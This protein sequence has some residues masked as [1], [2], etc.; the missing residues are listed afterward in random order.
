LFRLSAAWAFSYLSQFSLAI[1]DLA[2][3]KRQLDK[4]KAG[5]KPPF[6]MAEPNDDLHAFGW[7]MDRMRYPS[8]DSKPKDVWPGASVFGVPE[9]DEYRD[10][11][12]FNVAFLN[13]PYLQFMLDQ[14][15]E[16]RAAAEKCAAAKYSAE[17]VAALR[18]AALTAFRTVVMPDMEARFKKIAGLV[19]D[20]YAARLAHIETFGFDEEN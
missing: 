4:P 6:I 5:P 3:I 12:G 15:P 13:A 2:K 16:I 11:Y 10:T 9:A 19:A 1:G 18:K 20:Y 14:V 8:K 7:S 17:S